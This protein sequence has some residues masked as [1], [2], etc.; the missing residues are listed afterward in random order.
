MLADQQRFYQETDEHFIPTPAKYKQEA[1]FLKE[2]DSQALVSTHQQLFQAF[3]RFF[4]KPESFGYPQFKRKKSGKQSF[5]VCCRYFPSGPTV[6]LT[7][8]GVRLTKAGVVK[9]AIHRR[10]LHWWIL[11]RATVSRT[12][13]GKYYCS[14]LYGYPMRKPQEVAPDPEKTLGLNLSIPHFYVDSNGNMA[15]PPH[16]LKQS[17]E[18]LAAMQRKLSRMQ[19]G[20]KNYQQQLQK[21][22]LLH[23]HIANQRKDFAHKESRRI[24]NDW[25]A[26]CVRNDDLLETS[27]ELTMVNVL[28]TGF[29]FF[30][31]C[32]SYKLAL[33][34]K[35][36]LLV[37]QFNPTAKMC[38][39]CGTVRPEKISYRER[40][41]TCP[42]CGARHIHSVNAAKNIKALGLAQY[43]G[44][45][46]M[47]VTA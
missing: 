8:S 40:V 6:A 47:A 31:N 24:A 19:P 36:L 28:D 26:V 7:D 21:I 22:R 33:Q 4:R 27:R 14:L 17:Q 16:W 35:H 32:L 39:N 43:Y 18:K 29:G 30:R 44:S 34:G 42:S 23:E 12:S 1:P 3:Q 5:T 46:G 11:K 25:D 38:S 2:V 13:S 37:S 41:W 45:Q 15:D 9:A 20:S 10:P